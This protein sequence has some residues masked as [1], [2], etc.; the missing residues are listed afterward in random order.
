[1]ALMINHRKTCFQLAPFCIALMVLMASQMEAVSLLSI[2]GTDYG[3]CTF[4]EAKWI[5]PIAAYFFHSFDHE[6]LG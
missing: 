5:L 2:F 6:A 1:M 4:F 3:F